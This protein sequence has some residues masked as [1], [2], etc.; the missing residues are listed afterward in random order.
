MSSSSQA[1][2]YESPNHN[3]E[4][5]TLDEYEPLDDTVDII[6]HIANTNNKEPTT[7]LSSLEPL[8]E[9]T[10][11]VTPEILIPPQHT[12]K[13][14][15]AHTPP[16]SSIQSHQS[17]PLKSKPIQ[18]TSARLKAIAYTSLPPHPTLTLNTIPKKPHTKP[19]AHNFN[20]CLNPQLKSSMPRSY[21]IRNRVNK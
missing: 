12:S 19:I 9:P 6:S 2:S 4:N 18:H 5:L 14:T 13:S 11:R 8:P 3:P 15:P 10:P 7:H 17:S 20:V 1:T 21:E 16:N